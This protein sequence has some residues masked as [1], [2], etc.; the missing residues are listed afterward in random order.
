VEFFEGFRGELKRYAEG[1]HQLEPPAGADAIARAEQ[2]LGRALPADF[3]DFLAQWNGGFLFHDDLTLFG[4]G[5]PAA[6]DRL[7]AAGQEIRF[8]TAPG[9]ELRFDGAG[10]VVTFDE[11]TEERAVE[12]GGFA[13]WI[14][15]LMARER[16]VVDREGEVRPEALDGVELRLTVRRKRAE[17]AAR[18]DPGSAA[19]QEE[20]AA[21]R[22][23]EGR[24]GDARAALE[25]A[26]EIQPEAARLWLKL[27]ELAAAEPDAAAAARAFARAGEAAGEGEE[28]A[29]ALARA[30]AC[31]REARLP[32]ADGW[33]AEARR[34]APGLAAEQ[35]AAAEHLAGE[36]DVDG[37][38]ERIALARA[39]APDDE[40]V[41]R[42]EAGLRARL[43][44][45]PISG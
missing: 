8:G 42:V 1:V 20:L 11:A 14:E 25:R 19:W 32:E 35:R 16:L 45:R 18:I 34:R 9:S 38:L 43:R 39:I 26:A 4:A 12:G 17:A 41:A 3:R 13:R 2:R 5:G 22:A 29:F 21:V 30:A 10:R 36:G 24:A 33:A 23:E 40:A 28:A 27:G 15:A 37:A 31:G 44:L 6:L 7:E